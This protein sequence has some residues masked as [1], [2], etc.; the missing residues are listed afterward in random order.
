MGQRHGSGKAGLSGEADQG[1]T[2]KMLMFTVQE[3]EGAVR[4]PTHAAK[5]LNNAFGQG[6]D[7]GHCPDFGGKTS[8]QVQKI[9][10]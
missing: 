10:G 7:I 1:G 9:R 3:I 2:P 8:H 6:A 4:G 5:L